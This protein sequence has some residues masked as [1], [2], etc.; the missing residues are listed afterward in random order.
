VGILATHG[1]SS[2]LLSLSSELSGLGT[3]YPRGKLR[4]PDS[5]LLVASHA[6]QVILTGC[7]AQAVVPVTLLVPAACGTDAAENGSVGEHDFVRGDPHE[8]PCG[9]GN[10]VSEWSKSLYVVQ[11]TYHIRRSDLSCTGEDPP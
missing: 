3:Y 4:L 1:S 7:E 6:K 8:G 9:Y 2:R 5:A 10:K 11:G